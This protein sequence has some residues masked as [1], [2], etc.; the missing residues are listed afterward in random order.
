[1]LHIYLPHCSACQMYEPAMIIISILHTGGSWWLN[2]ISTITQQEIWSS[3][4]YLS[5]GCPGPN[6]GSYLQT[7][8]STS[9]TSVK[10]LLYHL[11]SEVGLWLRE[12]FKV[13]PQMSKTESC[14]EST[15]IADLQSIC[16]S[17]K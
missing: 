16:I 1:M 13:W 11:K 10:A 15:C 8:L 12:V 17:T 3:N 4:L 14:G 9:F 5:F 6:L 7:P 2:N